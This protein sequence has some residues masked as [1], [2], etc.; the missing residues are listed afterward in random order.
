M[1]FR[2]LKAIYRVKSGHPKARGIFSIGTAAAK[3]RQVRPLLN[4][5][6]DRGHDS[7]QGKRLQQHYL[8]NFFFPLNFSISLS[9]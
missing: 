8:F 9:V 4:V 5:A 7:G 2:N 3:V 1:E 6:G